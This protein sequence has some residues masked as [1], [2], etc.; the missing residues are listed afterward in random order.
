M[1]WSKFNFLYYSNIHKVHLLYNS[2][3]NSFIKVDNEEMLDFFIS[4][5]SKRSNPNIIE[6]EKLYKDLVKYNVIVE[7]DEI[8]ILKIKNT[9][10]GIRY[11]TDI[12]NLTI[13]P[14]LACN[15]K[16]PYCFSTEGEGCFMNEKVED[17]IF[18]LAKNIKENHGKIK[19]QLT[20]MGGE[21]LCNFKTMKR[22]TNKLL[23]LKTPL[24][25]DLVTNGYLLSKE[26]I[27]A[28]EKL[29]IESIQITLDGLEDEHNK[30]RI[31][32]TQ[33]K[34]FAKIIKNIDLFFELYP[35]SSNIS[36]NIR[37]NLDKKEDFSEKFISLYNYLRN[38]YPYKNLFI[39]P[40]FIDLITVDGFKSSC[41][42]D[43]SAIKDF[44]LELSKKHN[45]LEYSIYPKGKIN[46]CAIRSPFSYA[47]GPKGEIYPCW[48]NIGKDDSIIGKI[49]EKGNINLSNVNRYNKYIGGADYLTDEKCLKCF[50]FP[51]CNGGCPEKRILN[52]Y[53]ETEFDLCSVHKDNIEEI[54]DEHYKQKMEIAKYEKV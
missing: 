36:I 39:S 7:S 22:L 47:I 8:E 24:I 51:I 17:S 26:K 27:T 45:L 44:F 28:L 9:K 16:C 6:G 41:G 48:E 15:F 2:L 35:N 38:R 14:T 34:S 19:I 30:T 12:L 31:H 33:R 54:L 29:R 4:I 40:G 23:E 32:K 13:L 18:M 3:S 52:H 46:E 50:F 5:K 43:R 49:N 25:S 11:S 21:P 1:K 10:L 53:N 20:W 42:F 37:V